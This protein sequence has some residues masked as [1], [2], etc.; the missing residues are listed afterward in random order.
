MILLDT[1][2]LTCNISEWVTI[3][4]CA[5]SGVGGDG[6]HVGLSTVHVG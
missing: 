2:Y 6:D 4:A 5:G 1:V 3:Q